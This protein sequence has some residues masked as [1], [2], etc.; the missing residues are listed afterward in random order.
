MAKNFANIYAS[1]NDAIAL[2]QKFFL[3]EE[4]SRG[5]LVAPT[6]ADFLYTLPGGSVNFTQ[7][8]ESS[9]HRSGRHHTNIIKQKTSTEWSIPSFFNIDTLLGAPSVAEI[10]PA[11]RLLWKSLMGK[12]DITGGSPVFTSETP[13]DITF[14]I[15]ENG[16]LW[17][18]QA[19]GAFV[20]ANNVSL[21]GDGQAQNEWSGM[22]K[23]AYTVG[24][25]QSNADNNAGNTITLETGEG[26]RFPIG[27]MV[28]LTEADG[29]TRSADTP[30]G[31][32]RL[33]T[34]VVGDV[35]TVD[36]AA[37]ADAD[38]SGTPIYLS[39]YEPVEPH[40]AINDPQVGLTGSITIVGLGSADCVRSATINMVN[41]HEVQDFCYGEEGLGGRLFTPGG[42]FT[43][44]IGLEL[45]LNHDLVEFLNRIR[46]FD[47]EDITLILGDATGR[48]MQIEVPKAIFPVPEI[49]VPDTGTIPVS[50]TG[51]AYQTALDAADEVTVSFL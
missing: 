37:L 31:L 15:F 1:P 33:V 9:P 2:E 12:E 32:P 11:M 34:N 44:E 16:D 7:P 38:G 27:A 24:I 39:Y 13:P 3:K 14:S 50:F 46:N 4:S 6:A 35:V 18:L 47:G 23:T 36:G 8:I 10:D 19:P 26:E 17:A 45:N 22:A 30:T 43:A 29:T 48:H 49:S 42:R 25:G 28:M 5:V 40:V 20:E 51:N 21:P 41:N